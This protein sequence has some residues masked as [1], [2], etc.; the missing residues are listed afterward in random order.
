MLA[1]WEAEGLFSTPLVNTPTG[2]RERDDRACFNSAVQVADLAP[3]GVVPVVGPPLNMGLEVAALAALE[4][5][6][7]HA[8]VA[9]WRKGLARFVLVLQ[10]FTVVAGSI[11]RLAPVVSVAEAALMTASTWALTDSPDFV[12]PHLQACGWL[13]K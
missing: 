4:S 5:D 6:I 8:Q 9:Q 11:Q 13:P 12:T 1:D 2:R 10:S 7:Q 3:L